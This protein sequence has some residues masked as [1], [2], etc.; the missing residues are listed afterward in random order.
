MTS[1]WQDIRYAFRSM[2]TNP[3][4]VS[5]VILTLA[6]GVGANVAFV[7]VVRAVVWQPLPYRTPERVVTIWSQWV[8][9]P[10]TWVSMAEYRIYR[11]T[12][13]SFDAVGLYFDTSGNLTDGDDP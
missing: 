9:F 6:L 12:F 7:S 13:E 11:D 4:F 8:G 10:K 3:G 1:I 5:V 2:K